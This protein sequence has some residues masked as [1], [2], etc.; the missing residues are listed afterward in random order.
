M[1]SN[2]FNMDE[3]VDN[4][5][6]RKIVNVPGY[7]FFPFVV[8][9]LAMRKLGMKHRQIADM[10]NQK[11]KPEKPL[12][13]QSLSN[14]VSR[15][16]ASGLLLGLDIEVAS[17]AQTIQAESEARRNRSEISP[18]VEQNHAYDPFKEVD[19]VERHNIV[20]FL[21]RLE[22]KSE[23]PLSENEKN[24]AKDYFKTVDKEVDFEIAIEKCLSII[25]GSAV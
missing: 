21:K 19:P 10:L 18:P 7:K 22:K 5:E 16:K 11:V 6:N 23:R 9:I 2:T 3:L 13:N 20:E 15:W 14:L 24:V 12:T 4:F 17:L 8:E 1:K 25:S